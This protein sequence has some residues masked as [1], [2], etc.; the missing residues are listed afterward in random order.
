MRVLPNTLAVA[1]VSCFFFRNV[2]EGIGLAQ[3]RAS[4]DVSTQSDIRL[5]SAGR[6][7]SNTNL[8]KSRKIEEKPHQAKQPL[9]KFFHKRTKA[10]LGIHQPESNSFLDTE[11]LNQGGHVAVGA[12]GEKEGDIRTLYNR[13]REKRAE[14]SAEG[15]PGSLKT[16]ISVRARNAVH[17]KANQFPARTPSQQLAAVEKAW[18]AYSL[19]ENSYLRT[20]C[21]WDSSLPS[22]QG[23]QR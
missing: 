7:L 20:V 4:A 16:A 22:L 13:L 15:T 17:R 9:A 5:L 11:P 1:I 14:K 19:P 10:Q 23:P 2:S 18:S 21:P 3:S 8:V 12:S 6:Y